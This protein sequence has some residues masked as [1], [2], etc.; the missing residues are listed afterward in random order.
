[1]KNGGNERNVTNIDDGYL[2]SPEDGVMLLR[3]ALFVNT[4]AMDEEE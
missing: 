3:S 2:T 1:M 4:V